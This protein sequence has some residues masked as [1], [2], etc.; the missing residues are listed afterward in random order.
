MPVTGPAQLDRPKRL[1]ALFTARAVTLQEIPRLI[2][3]CSNAYAEETPG[4]SLE[5]TEVVDGEP[6]FELEATPGA[7]L[8]ESEIILRVHRL[9]DPKSDHRAVLDRMHHIDEEI[10]GIAERSLD[11]AQSYLALVGTRLLDP[12]R[13]RAYLNTGAL[14]GSALGA[15]FIDTAAVMVTT[16]PGEWAEACQQSL[17]IETALVR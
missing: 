11:G 12:G 1:L 17:D 9:D 13:V 6:I 2:E 7:L 3:V 10:G 14:I 15:L 4:A 5:V 8:K 16:D